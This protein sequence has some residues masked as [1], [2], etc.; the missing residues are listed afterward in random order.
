MSVRPFKYL[1]KQGLKHRAGR[2][3]WQSWSE[4]ARRL[5]DSVLVSDEARGTRGLAGR[6]HRNQAAV[7]TARD[8]L[9]FAA[10]VGNQSL[11]THRNAKSWCF[12]R[13]F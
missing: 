12:A 5:C 7:V 8:R 13:S 11:L 4:R 9:R 10:C 1:R 3:K 2:P 6:E